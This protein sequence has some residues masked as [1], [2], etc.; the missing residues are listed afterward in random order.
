MCGFSDGNSGAGRLLVGVADLLGEFEVI[1]FVDGF[2]SF[3][4]TQKFLFS[5]EPSHLCRPPYAPTLL[6]CHVG[7]LGDAH[8]LPPVPKVSMPVR[9][10]RDFNAAR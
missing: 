10:E 6:V 7:N 2:S 3:D 8:Q 1:D 4:H 5:L 9:L